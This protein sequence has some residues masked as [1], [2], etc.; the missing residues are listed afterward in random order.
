MGAEVW[1]EIYVDDML[2]ASQDV[3]D[4]GDVQEFLEIAVL[5]NH[6]A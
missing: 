5:Y 3:K 1:V 6:D 4:L 2:I